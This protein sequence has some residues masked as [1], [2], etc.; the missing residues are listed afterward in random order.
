MRLPH[1]I[2]ALALAAMATGCATADKVTESE[3][4]PVGEGFE[5]RAKASA[6]YPESSAGAEAQRMDWL[7][8]YLSDAGLCPNGYEI[9]K[10]TPVL[11][12]RAL[13]AD[14]YDIYYEGRCK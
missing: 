1:A 12:Q 9:T 2:L 10:R 8:Q 4:R 7:R 3:F 11:Q 6:S 5:Y 14:I 13:L